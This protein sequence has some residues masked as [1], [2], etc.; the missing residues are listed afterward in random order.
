MHKSKHEAE[1]GLGL[2]KIQVRE[3]RLGSQGK[4]DYLPYLSFFKVEGVELGHVPMQKLRSVHR[5]TCLGNRTG[6]AISRQDP[7]LIDHT[8]A[9]NQSIGDLIQLGTDF[10]IRAAIFPNGSICLSVP[11][12]QKINM[13]LKVGD[14][15]GKRKRQTLVIAVVPRQVNAFAVSFR[16]QQ[17]IL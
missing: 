1:K 13:T 11:W 6:S 3:V 16:K 17:S 9:V 12:P 14:I 10:S 15:L 4:D 8:Q 5:L 2:K 7:A